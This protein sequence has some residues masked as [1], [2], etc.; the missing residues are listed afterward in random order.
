MQCSR[1]DLP[2]PDGPMMAVNSP[3][4]NTTVTPSSART[5]VWPLPYTFVAS[6]VRAAAFVAV[7]VTGAVVTEVI[8]RSCRWFL[9]TRRLL[10][11]HCQRAPCACGCTGHNG[12]NR[13]GG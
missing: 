4:G 3:A 9:V 12:P 7:T 6:T 11:R 13:M 10:H 2:E 5:S 1:V 8:S